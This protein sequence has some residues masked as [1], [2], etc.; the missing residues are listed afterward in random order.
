MIKDKFTQLFEE[1]EGNIVYDF[2]LLD[3]FNEILLKEK[4][5]IPRLFRYSSADYYNIR[6][7]ETETLFLSISRILILF[8]LIALDRLA[9]TAV[10]IR[11]RKEF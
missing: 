9:L 7:L 6:A 1:T 4:S 3:Y 11:G 10:D 2:A 8:D 5:S